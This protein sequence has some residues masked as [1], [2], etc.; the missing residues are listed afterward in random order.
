MQFLSQHE[1]NQNSQSL[2]L[3]FNN[4]E[5]S[6]FSQYRLDSH[7]NKN[8]NGRKRSYIKSRTLD[9]SPIEQIKELLH[10]S[11]YKR[12]L[13]LIG[14]YMLPTSMIQVFL[15]PYGVA[16]FGGCYEDT[17][18]EMEADDCQPNYTKYNLYNSISL[19]SMGFVSF[20][21]SGF[22]GR[23]SDAYGR[24]PFLFMTMVIG[25]MCRGVMVFYEDLWLFLGLRILY[26][27]NGGRDA[28][29]PVMNAYF[30]YSTTNVPIMQ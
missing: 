1:Q 23:L 13:V 9:L 21:F 28:Q 24:K 19:S 22:F 29:T 26:G 6:S 11:P 16:W 4:T 14:F 20:L 17:S 7:S 2:P 15:T 5:A 27:L 3:S 25:L 12:L 30:R 10:N 8:S 18:S